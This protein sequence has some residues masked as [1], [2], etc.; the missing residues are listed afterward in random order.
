MEDVTAG[1]LGERDTPSWLQGQNK[2]KAAEIASH[3]AQIMQ[4]LG[5][6]LSD[7]HL[8]GTPD[9]V[10]RMYM[11]IF[12]ELDDQGE[13][14]IT[15]F[16]NNDGYDNMVIVKDIEFFSVCSHHLIP[17][18]GKAHIA[19]IPRDSI[20][21][22]SKIVR[23]VEFYA[24]RPQLQERLTQQIVDFLEAKLAPKGSIVV[25]EARHLCMEMRG[26][27]RPGAITTTSALR[28]RFAEPIVREEFF[29]LIKKD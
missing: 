15:C 21:G 23:I 25:M 8:R 28:G 4:V 29:N 1:Q 12:R 20:V 18:F 3:F 13:P 7:P 22:L 24:R 26:V 19:Y 9:R 6:D 2:A 11:E 16:P 17:F 5:L 10:G 27:E 14:E